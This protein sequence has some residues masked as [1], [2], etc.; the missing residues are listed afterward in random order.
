[1]IDGVQ[2][3]IFKNCRGGEYNKLVN[4]ESGAGTIKPAGIRT[5]W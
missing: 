2:S 3:Y 4:P 5:T 1:M